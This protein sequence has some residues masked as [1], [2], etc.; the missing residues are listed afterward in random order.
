MLSALSIKNIAVIEKV[1]IEFDDGLNILT[2]E[3]GAG[4][5]ILIDSINAVIGERTS[6]D[7]IRTG[8]EFGRVSALFCNLSY[9]DKSLIEELGFEI[10][11]DNS[12]LIQ[13]DIWPNKNTCKI[14]GQPCNITVLK[15]LGSFLIN[16]H[17]QHDNQV[18]LRPENHIDILDLIG[19]Y[20]DLLV[21][22]KKEYHHM[23]EIK[24][25][26]SSTNMDEAQKIRR[27]DLLKYQIEELETANLIPGEVEELETQRKI[28]KNSE[29]ISQAAELVKSYLNGID[30]EKGAV[31]LISSSA[32]VLDQITGFYPELENLALKLQEMKYELEDGATELRTVLDNLDFDPETLEDIE[33]RLDYIHKLGRKYGKDI[34]SMLTFLD[35]CRNELISI[36][37]SDEN[38]L[39]LQEEL[40]IS[41]QLVTKLAN[42][43]TLKREKTAQDFNEKVKAELEFLD[44]PKVKLKV[45]QMPCTFGTIGADNIEFLISVNPG[46]PPKSISK[47][48]SGGELSRIMLAIKNVLADKD[49]IDT[50]IF[51]EIDTGI[52]GRAAG[53]VGM[54]LKEVSKNRQIICVTHSAQIACYADSHYKIEKNFTSAHAFTEVNKL[55]YDGKIYELARITGGETITDITLEN[56]K[57]MLNS[58]NKIL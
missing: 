5:S 54:K 58:A 15:K 23:C 51:D 31:E 55:D 44:M 41:T 35:E 43:L 36:E 45:L 57:E 39:K 46:E 40:K 47:I 3:T 56:A 11:D 25:N 50:L 19:D 32:S 28:I 48:A 22:Y 13:R 53:K 21:N 49:N 17:G 20:N 4:K 7:I 14:N 8:S 16:I 42:E 24:R 37:L 30:N 29:K 9:R 12:L 18:L 34:E 38:T 2:G 26:L 27:I 33:S 1:D 52:S 6:R 10:D